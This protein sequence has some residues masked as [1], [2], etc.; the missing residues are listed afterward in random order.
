MNSITEN[1]AKRDDLFINNSYSI[2]KEKNYQ[3][4]LI[5][6]YVNENKIKIIVRR[7]DN[8]Y[9]WD[10]DLKFKL[11]SLKK[12]QN[13]IYSIGSSEENFKIIELYTS[14]KVGIKENKNIGIPKVIIQTNNK[15]IKNLKHYNSICT[16]LEYNPDY[17]Y[18][19]FDDDN[20]RKFISDNF[21]NNILEKIYVDTNQSDVLYAYDY[22]IP[23][24]I[25]ADLFRYCYL[26]VN[27]GFYFDSK[28]ICLKS[29]DDILDETD[30][31]FLCMDDAKN[32]IYNGIIGVKKNNL[33]I[34]SLITQC[35]TNILTKN[36][37]N[38]IH[39]PTGNKLL[40]SFLKN[41]KIILN[42]STENIK[43]K[44]EIVFISNYKNY[45]NENYYNFRVDWEHKKYYYKNITKISDYL[46]L[47]NM[48]EYKDNFEIRKLKKNIFLIKRVDSNNGWEQNLKINYI[49]LLNNKK[50]IYDIGSSKENEK[51]FI[52]D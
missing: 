17:E 14:I 2:I 49:N 28:V 4:S 15:I 43:Y 13:K 11:Y 52:L 8:D 18:L 47:I 30:E 42:K 33:K 46:F 7:L 27:G 35:V 40:F 36:H 31:Y 44:N 5:I 50:L 1:I 22:I 39:E 34:L 24:A 32:S 29:I 23:G 48:N 3:L 45:Y 51:I 25:K 19:F 12:D 21:K 9:G 10:Y 26:Y 6:Y 38:D 16:L 20:A 37:C 41:E